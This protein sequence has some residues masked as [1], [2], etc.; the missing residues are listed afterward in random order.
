MTADASIAGL[1]DANR[2][3]QIDILRTV[4]RAFSQSP[5]VTQLLIRGSLNAGR[6]D[7]SSDVDLVVCAQP[8]ALPRIIENIDC[9]IRTSVGCLF[10]GWPDAV[11]PDLGGAGFVF[12][13]PFEGGLYELD[14]YVATASAAPA[15]VAR[16]ATVIYERVDERG[17]AGSRWETAGAEPSIPGDGDPVRALIVEVLVVFHLLSKRVARG[18]SF[19]VYGYLYLLNDAIRRLIK[20]QLA[21]R[22]RHWGWY[23]LEDDLSFKPRG[24]RCLD[25]LAGLVNTSP[26]IHAS[27]LPRTF[28]RIARIAE[29]ATGDLWAEMAHEVEA[30]RYYLGVQE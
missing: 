19:I 29:L 6:A 23:H 27:D 14:I 13:V 5:A 30:Y 4:V 1:L 24:K 25:E 3:P 21:P 18:Q 7:R 2:P 17:D 28:A 11:A 10:S 15:I 9:I 12:L 22:S 16:G 20:H 8:G 26:N